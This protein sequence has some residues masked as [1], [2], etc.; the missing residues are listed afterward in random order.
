M[1]EGREEERKMRERG[2]DGSRLVGEKGNDVSCDVCT[3]TYTTTTS[4]SS[5]FLA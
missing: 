3:T 4:S 1:E 2:E 5:L